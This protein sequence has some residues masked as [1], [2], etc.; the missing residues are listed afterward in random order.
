MLSDDLAV[1]AKQN[2]GVVDDA[3]DFVLGDHSEREVSLIAFG[4]LSQGLYGGAGHLLGQL[5][6]ADAALVA[7]GC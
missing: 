7:G 1:A 5:G 4:A 2:G 3:L 6:K